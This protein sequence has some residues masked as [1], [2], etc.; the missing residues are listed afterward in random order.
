MKFKALALLSLVGLVGCAAYGVAPTQSPAITPVQ[1]FDA[2]RYLGKWYELGRIENSF[3]RGMFKTTAQYSLN[4][5]GSIKVVNSGYDPAK[6]KFRDAT[7]KAKFVGS[8]NV[9]AL[10]VSFFGPFYGGYNVVAL[11]D[12]YQWAIVVGPNPNK[13]FWVLSRQPKLTKRLKDKALSVAKGLNVDAAK[14]I[15]VQQ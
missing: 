4:S 9:G 2:N 14:I 7:G 3:E 13:Y 1:N 15:W 12:Q 6:Q 11:D 5:D 10:K 8:P